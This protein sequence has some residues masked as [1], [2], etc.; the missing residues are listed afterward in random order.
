MGVGARTFWKRGLGFWEP[1][2]GV[3]SLIFCRLCLGLWKLG[4]EL[5]IGG[6]GCLEMVVPWSRTDLV[7][8]MPLGSLRPAASCGL[9]WPA[10]L[11]LGGIVAELA[12]CQVDGSG[13]TEGLGGRV[14]TTGDW[15]LRDW[16][17]GIRGRVERPSRITTPERL[18]DWGIG[19]GWKGQDDWRLEVNDWRLGD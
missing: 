19:I 7:F 12:T 2:L 11:A 18:K 14:R 16:G 15:R 6:L 4:P 9:G 13:A 3:E 10:G 5:G 8:C 1:D 17:I